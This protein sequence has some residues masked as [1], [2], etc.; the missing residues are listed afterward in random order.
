MLYCARCQ[1]ITEADC[2]HCGRKAKKLAEVQPH[3]PVFL[4]SCRLNL[5]G[6]ITPLLDDAGIPYSCMGKLGA[7]LATQLGSAFE[8]YNIYVPYGL[9]HRAYSLIYQVFGDDP[10]VTSR[11]ENYGWTPDEIDAFAAE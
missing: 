11:L 7:A 2:P 6:M 1:L 3:D 8:L 4:I 10:E 5:H 9:F